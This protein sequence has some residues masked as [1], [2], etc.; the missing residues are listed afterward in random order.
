MDAE[1]FL[2]ER[3]VY[4]HPRIEDVES[5]NSYDVAELMEEY[6]RSKEQELYDIG[7][8]E[9]GHAAASDILGNR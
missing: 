2:N 5:K 4:N 1:E 7:F 8:T 6:A 3:G 9:G